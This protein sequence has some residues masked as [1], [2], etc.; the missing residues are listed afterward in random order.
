MLPAVQGPPA[1]DHGVRLG[2][3]AL[4]NLLSR[5]WSRAGSAFVAVARRPMLAIIV[6]FVA[7]F[8]VAMALRI[9]MG[10]APRPMVHD[11]LSYVLGAE[12]FLRG[13]VH[14]VFER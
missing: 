4:G 7:T 11:E 3:R 13:R 6:V 1:T 12:T 5:S 8:G 2:R 9:A 10:A 14:P